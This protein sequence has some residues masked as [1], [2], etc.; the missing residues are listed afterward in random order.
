VKVV[1]EG[2]DGAE[3]EVT[4]AKKGDWI[5]LGQ[6]YNLGWKATADGKDLGEPSLVDGYANGWQLP[7][8]AA[9]TTIELTWTPQ[10]VVWGAIVLSMIAILVTILLVWGPWRRRRRTEPDERLAYDAEPS[11]PRTFSWAR[12]LR[13]AGP[14]P[15]LFATVATVAGAFVLGTLVIGIVPGVAL[16]V[17]ALV[18]LRFERAR[19]LLTIGAVGLWGITCA[20]VLVTKLFRT[21]PSGFEWPTYFDPVHQVA[22]SAV[23]L[24][25]LDVVID[26][27]WLRRWWPTDDSPS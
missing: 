1:S 9:T 14:R 23:A 16:A 6:S 3:L 18:A 8:D 11:M 19:P 10:R 21:L 22:W 13:Y 27:C 2:R 26:R 25:L 7:A 24:I 5:V 17:V 15:S 12:V 4:D 20:Y